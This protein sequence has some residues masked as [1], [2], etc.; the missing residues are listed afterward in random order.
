MVF[1]DNSIQGILSYNFRT[2][3]E[4]VSS[5]HCISLTLF[6][7]QPMSIQITKDLWGATYEQIQSAGGYPSQ[8]CDLILGHM[9]IQNGHM[10]TCL[11]DNTCD[12]HSSLSYSHRLG[13]TCISE[14]L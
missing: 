7:P 11:T 6:S 8:S 13:T 9:V 2:I 3:Q 5:L 10:V 14:P 12:H 1:H 4:T